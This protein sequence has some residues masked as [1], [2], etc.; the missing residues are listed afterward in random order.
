MGEPM[1]KI[2]L[3]DDDD[4][5]R[6]AAARLIDGLGYEVRAVTGGRDA[7]AALRADPADLVLLD[8][9]MP[10]E[11]GIEV[12]RRL[13]TE[14]PG[15]RVVLITGG[16]A[17]APELTL[18]LARRLGALATLPKPFTR[19]E[20]AQT[21]QRVLGGDLESVDPASG[22]QPAP[23]PRPETPEGDS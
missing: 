16:G 12:I 13:S 21:L 7:Y 6:T 8:V 22:A 9:Y 18:T 1:A 23:R 20:L 4:A 19:D 2:L 10:E 5:F 15:I 11:D 14:F 3:V 17:L